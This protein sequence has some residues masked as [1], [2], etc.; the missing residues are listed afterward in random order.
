[1]LYF[2]CKKLFKKSEE[3][4]NEMQLKKTL[5]LKKNRPQIT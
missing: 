5:S 1:M 4:K 3:L 2:N